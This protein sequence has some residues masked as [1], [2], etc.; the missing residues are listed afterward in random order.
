MRPAFSLFIAALALIVFSVPASAR[1]RQKPKV[2]DASQPASPARPA[3]PPANDTARFLAGMPISQNSPIA[4]LTNTAAW[5]EHSAYFEKAFQ[6][7]HTAAAKTA[8][9][10]G[11]LSAGIK[12][13]RAGRLLHVQ[14]PDFLYVDQFFPNASVYILCGKESMGPPPDPLRI[15]NLDAAFQNLENAM[16]S[17][18]TTN[19]FITQ[20]MKVRLNQQNLS[21]TLPIFYV[22]LARADKRS[23]TSRS[24]R[25]T[26]AV[27]IIKARPAVAERPVS[28]STTPTTARDDR[29]RCSISRPISRTAASDPVPGS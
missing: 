19:Y 15:G 4:P 27:I 9:L 16:K 25:S 7:E 22:F 17:I 23:A 1:W 28:A 21:G 24:S 12:G 11:C 18:L 5:Q 8:S 2:T 26:R 10:A 13:G 20:E 6:N 14:R 29:K 3:L